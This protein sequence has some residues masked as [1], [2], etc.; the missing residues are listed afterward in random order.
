MP[1]TDIHESIAC[2]IIEKNRAGIIEATDF[3]TPFAR[4]LRGGG[5]K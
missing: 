5:C 3:S 1:T 2:A 4:A